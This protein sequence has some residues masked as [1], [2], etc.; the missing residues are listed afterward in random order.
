METL[1][2]LLNFSVPLKLLKKKVYKTVK[3]H[4]EVE[5][6]RNAMEAVWSR[7]WGEFGRV[8]ISDGVKT[9]AGEV[10]VSNPA[11]ATYPPS[12]CSQVM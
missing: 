7:G 4:H 1:G 10:S 11:S 2:T 12:S 9:L 5:S 6:Q 8:V 3:E